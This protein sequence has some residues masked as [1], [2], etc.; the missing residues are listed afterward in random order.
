MT[1]IVKMGPRRDRPLRPA[2]PPP[3][4]QARRQRLEAYIAERGLKHS[5]QRDVIVS[6]FFAAPGHVS[7]EELVHRARA[8]DQKVSVATVYRTLKLLAESGLAVALDFGDGQSRWESALDRSHHDHLVCR[9]CGAIV[10][11]ANDEIERL[12]AMVARRHGFVV[13]SHRLELYGTCGG[14]RRSGPGGGRG[15]EPA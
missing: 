13:E 4:D 14:C 5:R 2:T 9:R 10:E 3:P 1:T 8:G 7:A 11:F 15:Q 12:Q 6:A